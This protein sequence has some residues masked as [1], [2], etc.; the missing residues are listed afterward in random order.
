MNRLI[1]DMMVSD[2]LPPTILVGCGWMDML[3]MMDK[4][5]ELMD[6]NTDMTDMIWRSVTTYETRWLWLYDR[7]G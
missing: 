2:S 7:D 1:S 3:D 4:E 5:I 6:E